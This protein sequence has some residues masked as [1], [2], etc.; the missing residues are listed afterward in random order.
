MRSTRRPGR[1]KRGSDAILWPGGLWVG[2]RYIRPIAG[3]ESNPPKPGDDKPENDGE[4]GNGT[5]DDK[6]KPDAKPQFT[7]ADVDRIVAERLAREQKKSA[8]AAEKARREAE[9]KAA[10]EQGEFKKLADQRQER[11]AALEAQ[12]AEAQ[13]FKEKAERYEGALKAHLDEM[14]KGLPASTLE[15]LDGR[16]VVDQMTWLAKHRDEVVGA[17]AG[18][19]G[20]PASPRA[21]GS[22]AADAIEE[23]RKKLAATGAYSRF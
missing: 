15:L 23:N 2:D 22:P 3:G 13:A 5:P 21:N 18:K 19:N 7:Q 4:D 16:D 10:A 12:V 9:D 8:D 1:S 6:S 20:P 17:A 14:R 11:I